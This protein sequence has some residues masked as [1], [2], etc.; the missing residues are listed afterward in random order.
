MTTNKKITELTELVEADIADD[1]VPFR[2]VTL[3]NID[4]SEIL[5][6][7]DADGNIYYEVDS[8]TQDTV[9]SAIENL[10]KDNKIVK[11]KIALRSAPRRFIRE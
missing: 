3:S 11:N 4:V 5:D 8:L 7:R 10:E 6:L 2:T 9:F 1:Y